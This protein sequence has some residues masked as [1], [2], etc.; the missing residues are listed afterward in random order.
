[1]ISIAIIPPQV[2]FRSA[3][4]RFELKIPKKDEEKWHTKAQRHGLAAKKR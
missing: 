2:F 4:I 3:K 1:M